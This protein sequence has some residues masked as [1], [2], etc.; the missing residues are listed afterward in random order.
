MPWHLGAI[1][2]LIYQQLFVEVAVITDAV[3]RDVELQEVIIN[4]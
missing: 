2:L 3:D 4:P 1:G